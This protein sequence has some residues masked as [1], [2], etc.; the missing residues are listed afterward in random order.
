MRA[1]LTVFCLFWGSMD[2]TAA[3]NLDMSQKQKIERYQTLLCELASSDPR[4]EVRAPIDLPESLKSAIE[5]WT[6]G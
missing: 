5:D 4:Q 2:D 3:E 1:I 6:R